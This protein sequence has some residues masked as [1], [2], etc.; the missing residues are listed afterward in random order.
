MSFRRKEEW[1]TGD[2]SC[3]IQW[4]LEQSMKTI[5]W[6]LQMIM[7]KLHFI[8]IPQI[9]CVSIFQRI[10]FFLMREKIFIMCIR[11]WNDKWLEWELETRV[12]S[13]WIC[14]GRVFIKDTVEEKNRTGL[15]RPLVWQTKVVAVEKVQRED[16]EE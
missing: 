7:E 15:R 11:K 14:L 8:Q 13:T 2:S 3:I 5:I 10:V 1:I 12:Y 6:A 9:S 4:I 16:F